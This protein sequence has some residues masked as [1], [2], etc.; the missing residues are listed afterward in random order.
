LPQQHTE[1]RGCQ[2]EILTNIKFATKTDIC[3]MPSNIFVG[4]EN[5]CMLMIYINLNQ[6]EG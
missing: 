4:I 6:V 2:R 3:N 5:F 1:Q